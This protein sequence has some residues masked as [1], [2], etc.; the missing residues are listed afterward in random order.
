M[1]DD[2][3]AKPN[4]WKYLI[5]TPKFWYG[6]LAMLLAVLLSFASIY[7]TIETRT[8]AQEWERTDGDDMADNSFKLFRPSEIVGN[9]LYL[10]YEGDDSINITIY[11]S[12]WEHLD[13]EEL[14][15]TNNEYEEEIGRDASWLIFENFDQGK[16]QME[17]MVEYRAQK[18]SFLAVIALLMTLVGMYLISKGYQTALDRM[19]E[20]LRYTDVDDGYTPP[21]GDK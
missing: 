17:H 15:S 10:F 5:H 2:K 11:D 4:T 16:L 13:D 6:F 14:T 8:V 3:K 18:Y 1:N 9:N 7:P 12:N 21:H 19:V 20:D